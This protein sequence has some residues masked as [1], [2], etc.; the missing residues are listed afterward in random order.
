M[1]YLWNSMV[2]LFETIF[3]KSLYVLSNIVIGLMLLNIPC[4]VFDLASSVIIPTLN[5]SG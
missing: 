3:V 5:A 2:T 1:L 4:D